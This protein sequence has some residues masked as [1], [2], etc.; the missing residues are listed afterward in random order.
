MVANRRLITLA[1]IAL[2]VGIAIGWNDSRPTWDDTG[3]TAGL[4]VVAAAAFGVVDPRRW[5]LWALLVGVGTPL[6]EMS[7]EVG[8]AS[9]AAF[10]FSGVGAAGGAGATRLLRSDRPRRSARFESAAN[11]PVERGDDGLPL[12]KGER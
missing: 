9:L 2:I 10:V 1:A 4:L 5:W 6:V 11:E 12:D 8:S 3:I 7:G